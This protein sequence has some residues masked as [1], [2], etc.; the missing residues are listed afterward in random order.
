MRCDI[1]S[2][3]EN[4]MKYTT[5]ATDYDGTIAHH[6]D[7]D[8]P[9]IG[10]LVR[11]RESGRKL[12]LVTGREIPDLKKVFPHLELFDLIVAEN[13]ALLHE[14]R[15]GIEKL[16]AP[17]TPKRFVELLRLRAVGSLSVG[18]VI[19]ATQEPY[20]GVVLEAIKELGLSLEVIPNK[21]SLMVLPAGVNKGTGLAA[22]ARE[23]GISMDEIVGVGDAENDRALFEAC[24]Y[25]AAVANALPELK[26]EVN[27]VLRE[28]HG[29][30]VRELID[31]MLTD[32]LPRRA[33]QRH[34]L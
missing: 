4:L 22:G 31:R 24:G 33:V 3:S 20:G 21:G 30:G 11:L 14:P 34:L 8:A 12:M 32:D 2:R 26:S 7:V 10:A 28:G 16:L 29:A 25:A 9:T 19:V 6:G 15:T 13:G 5:L 18:R 23:L 1:L 17:E 27:L